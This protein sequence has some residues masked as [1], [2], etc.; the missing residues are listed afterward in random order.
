MGNSLWS[1][2]H[3]YINT[4]AGSEVREKIRSSR[5]GSTSTIFGSIEGQGKLFLEI[6]VFPAKQD[7]CTT[8]KLRRDDSPSI[9]RAKSTEL[10]LT[11]EKPFKNLNNL[12]K[13]RDSNLAGPWWVGLETAL[14]WKDHDGYVA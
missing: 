4:L 7:I 1:Q 8:G 5:T 14:H 11:D 2:I 13:I 6:T 10:Q 3:T 12:S 9:C